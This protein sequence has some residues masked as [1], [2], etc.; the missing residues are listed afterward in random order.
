MFFV[1]EP[2]TWNRQVAGLRRTLRDGVHV[3]TPHIPDGLPQ[4]ATERALTALMDQ[5]VRE[6][7][8]VQPVLWYY[9]PM[10][11]PWTRQ[12]ERSQLV[13]DSMDY[14]GGFK[15]AARELL[16]LESELLASSDL[17]FTGGASLHERM[18][19]RHQ[20]AH[21]FPSSVDA[22]HFRRARV[23]HDPPDQRPIGQPRIGYAGVIDERLDLGLIRDVAAARPDWSIVLVGPVAKIDPADVPQGPNIHA[24]GMKAYAELPAYLGSWS[25][26]WMPF[27][28]NDA[29]RYISPT[30]TPEYLAAGLPVVSTSIRDVIEPYGNRGLVR[31]ADAAFDTVAAMEA[32]IAGACPSRGDVDGFLAD[33]S[34]DRTWRE[35]A[36]LLSSAGMAVPPTTPLTQRRGDPT[37][38]AAE[39]A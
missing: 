25:V 8:I 18:V 39:V 20:N 21:C 31:I 37:R 36:R 35:M 26:G 1:E 16:T 7:S 10:A 30:K 15:G 22:E 3:V 27:A 29:T 28:R 24:L 14:L 34:W 38:I 19:P 12:L 2:T 23:A 33:L 32:V 13:Y 11:L 4:S 6:D 9:T 17:V 5:M